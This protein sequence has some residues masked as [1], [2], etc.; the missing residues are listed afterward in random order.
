MIFLLNCAIKVSL[1]LVV[2]LIAVRLLRRQS[3]ATR[4][5][6]L[7]AGILSAAI[8]PGLSA[9]IPGWT[10]PVPSS[11]VAPPRPYPA[12]AESTPSIS[13]SFIAMPLP[14]LPAHDVPKT[15]QTQ[16]I[17][18]VPAVSQRDWFSYSLNLVETLAVLW[19][20]GFVISF[21][22]LLVG[23]ARL[24]WIARRSRLL[25]SE[26]WTQVVDQV[27]REYALPR[28]PR[29]IQN[30]RL[31]VLFT[32]GWR[33]PRVL[34]PESAP[35][36]PRERVHAVLCHELAHIRRADWVV[37]MAAEFVRTVYWFNPL[38]WVACRYLR[39]ESEQA[40]DDAAVN[41]GIA[42][43]D[44]AAH[45]LDVVKSLRHPK[46]AWSY[47]LSMA[48]PSTLE[49][50]FVAMLNPSTNR[51]AM[52]RLSIVAVLALIHISEPTRL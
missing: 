25:N 47:A 13:H 8:T 45:L 15:Q 32:W 50:R 42:G 48:G 20:A 26:V 10:W 19:I 39:R 51:Q 27:T 18:P 21:S 17:S 6:V 41:S 3:A 9:L 38:L 52:T 30:S 16:R 37:Q 36:W 24:F 23:Y 29:L 44:Y 49:Q 34:V 31:S 14:Q 12:S 2:T 22:I 1:I 11:I 7:A 4:H 35:S 28:A 40:C 43:S 46:R 5:F 33:R